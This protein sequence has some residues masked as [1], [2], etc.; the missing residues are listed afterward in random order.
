MSSAVPAFPSTP[1]QFTRGWNGARQTLRM[2][3]ALVSRAFPDPI[4]AHGAWV[5]LFTSVGAGAMVGAQR[6]VETAMLVGTGFAGGLLGAAAVAVGLRGKARQLAIAGAAFLPGPL[7]A[8]WLGA[9]R[10]FLLVSACAAVAAF[11]AVAPGKK[12]RLPVPRG[13]DDGHRGARPGCSS[14]GHGWEARAWAGRPCC[15]RCFALTCAESGA[16]CGAFWARGVVCQLSAAPTSLHGGGGLPNA[17]G[18]A[19]SGRENTST[20]PVLLGCPL[21]SQTRRVRYRAGR[22]LE[23]MWGQCASYFVSPSEVSPQRGQ[24][25]CAL[26]HDLPPCRERID[27]GLAH[28]RGPRTRF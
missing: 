4:R 6:G 5:Y 16:C 27:A 18:K 13:S 7:V 22:Q 8:L 23:L 20:L 24:C 11:G 2:A 10:G 3:D 1:W 14:G 17:D 28:V 15:S 19:N 12:G 9:E 26:A 25:H 21:G